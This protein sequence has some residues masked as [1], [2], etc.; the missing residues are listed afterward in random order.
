MNLV[1]G[2]GSNLGDRKKHIDDAIDLLQ[3][4]I[5]TAEIIKSSIYEN[6]AILKEG[7]PSSWDINFYN[8][9]IMGKTELDPLIIL[10]L[11]KE[12]ETKIGRK[13]QGIWAPREIDIDILAY[14][15]LVMK[16]KILTIPHNELLKR[17][18]AIVPFVEIYGN[19]QY[20]VQSEFY[21]LHI[22]VILEKLNFSDS[23]FIKI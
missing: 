14:Q 16:D 10:K 1:L 11:I 6:K 2:L 18:C 13:E 9:A 17:K 22:S 15:D 8:I 20:P 7:S 19:W 12:I 21:N 23:L 5:F 4:R 3:E